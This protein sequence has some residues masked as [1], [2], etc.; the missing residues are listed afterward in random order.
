MNRVIV[1]GALAIA[2][3]SLGVLS[4][5]QKGTPEEAREGRVDGSRFT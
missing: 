4:F 1:A 2:V 5:G 3:L